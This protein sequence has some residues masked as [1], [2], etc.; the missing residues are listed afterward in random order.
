MI[1]ICWGVICWLGEIRK[2]FLNVF[3]VRNWVIGSWK[4]F[5]I[6]M[7]GLCVVS[8]SVEYWYRLWI[9]RVGRS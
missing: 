7:G 5:D 6:L 8:E 9:Y 1:F 2:G 3:G 4:I